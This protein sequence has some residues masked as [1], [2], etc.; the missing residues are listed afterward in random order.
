MMR[1][2]MITGYFFLIFII[3]LL[4][5]FLLD[6][7]STIYY[8]KVENNQGIV[9]NLVSDKGDI[10]E[11]LKVSDDLQESM[12]VGDY[13]SVKLSN[14]KNNIINEQL[15]DDSQLSSKILYHLNI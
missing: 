4:F 3:V 11:H 12:H 10:I 5:I 7:K 2:S 15:V 8:G 6:D 14:K 9:S 1:T 13:I